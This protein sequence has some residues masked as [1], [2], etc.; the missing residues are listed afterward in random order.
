MNGRATASSI[1]FQRHGVASASRP[2]RQRGDG[3]TFDGGRSRGAGA[4]LETAPRRSDRRRLRGP[5]GRDR[6]APAP[7]GGGRCQLARRCAGGMGLRPVLPARLVRRRHPDLP[8]RDDAQRRFDARRR[9]SNSRPPVHHGCRS[10][11][12]DRRRLVAVLDRAQERRQSARSAGQGAGES[13]GSRRLGRPRPLTRTDD[14]RRALCP[15]DALRRQRNHGA[16]EHSL[17][18][19]PPLVGRRRGPVVGLHVH[20]GLQRCDHALRLSAR[21]ARHLLAHHVG[22]AGSY[23]LRRPAAKESAGGCRAD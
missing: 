9:G 1:A 2:T 5:P 19:L 11:R 22:C 13:E 14:R 23:L 3:S 12:R 16:L 20:V 15:R 8:R 17:P 6:P 21:V 18:P 7:G 10:A 4:L